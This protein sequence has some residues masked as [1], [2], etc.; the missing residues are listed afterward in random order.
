MATHLVIMA[1][2][3]GSRFWPMSTPER[4]KQFLDIT[5]CGHTMIQQTVRRFEGIVDMAHVWVVT[6]ASFAALVAQQLEGIAPQ[7]ILL[8]PC[9]RNTAPCIAYAA[10]KIRKEDP[11]ATLIVAPSDHLVQDVPAFKN[12]IVKGV[13]FVTKDERILTLG[14][15][16]TRPETGYG[17][18]EQGEPFTPAEGASTKD[19]ARGQSLNT[20]AEGSDTIAPADYQNHGAPSIA[21]EA[22]A[23]IFTLKAFKE[24]PQLDVAKAYLAQGGFTWN[25]GI[26]LWG[27]DTII[28]QI[29]LHC[30]ELAKVM[31]DLEPSLLTDEEPAALARL[32]PTCP[33]IS[34]DYAVM[35]KTSCAFVMPAEFGWSDLGTWGSLLQLSSKDENGNAII[36]AAQT[37][38][39]TACE[40][41]PTGSP[42]PAAQAPDAQAGANAPAAQTS[43]T[44][45]ALATAPDTSDATP[46]TD[47]KLVDC[48]GCIVRVPSGKKLV[49][50]GLR[51]CIVAE[52]D[53]T[54]MIC[55]LEDEQ[56]IKDWH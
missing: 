48:K 2:G 21:P 32:F 46:A 30:P 53:G 51:D 39:A 11:R 36:I 41:D 27:A 18:I 33:K 3:I 24:K 26:F 49:L 19:I 43:A 38:A 25:S 47:M 13:D 31:D 7:H 12:A 50:Q 1:G 29:R 45:D 16:P 20:T 34:I 40:S 10:W 9:M 6:G 56:H 42:A 44:S 37:P 8:E 22:C 14:M 35:E 23:N 5:G 28:S 4:P 15:M 52:H 17:Y 55:R 54:L